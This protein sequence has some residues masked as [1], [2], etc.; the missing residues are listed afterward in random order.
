MNLEDIKTFLG[1]EKRLDELKSAYRAKK[2][3]TTKA[4]KAQ[5]RAILEEILE[6]NAVLAGQ[7]DAKLER[8]Q[9]FRDDLTRRAHRCRALLRELD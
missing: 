2:D 8:M 5:R 4:A 1:S 9:A 3:V 7:L 6:V